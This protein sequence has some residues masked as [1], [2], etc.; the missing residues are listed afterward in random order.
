[1]PG[2]PFQAQFKSELVPGDSLLTNVLDALQGHTDMEPEGFW[3]VALGMGGPQA[4]EVFGGTGSICPA[5]AECENSPQPP[6]S[7]SD[8]EQSQPHHWSQ[9]Q[10]GSGRCSSQVL[11]PPAFAL[12]SW[13]STDKR[14]AKNTE[15]AFI[16]EGRI[17]SIAPRLINIYPK[18]THHKHTL[19]F[20]ASIRAIGKYIMRAER[21]QSTRPPL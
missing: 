20:E 5:P 8:S 17:P 21:T 16:S 2:H 4:C 18:C 9:S 10:A 3:D 6:E 15:K 1:M 19:T 7:P 12:I 13:I 14:V 11:Q